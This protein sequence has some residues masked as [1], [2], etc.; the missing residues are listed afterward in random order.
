MYLGFLIRSLIF[1][2]LGELNND[3]DVTV[4]KGLLRQLGYGR[5]SNAR[6]TCF[7]SKE[8]FDD[9][10]QFQKDNGLKVDGVITPNGETARTIDRLFSEKTPDDSWGESDLEKRCAKLL[11]IDE[12]MCASLEKPRRRRGHYKHLPQGQPTAKCWETAR[13][14]YAHCLAGKPLD[15]LPPLNAWNH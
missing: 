4:T 2:P 12:E 15:E 3:I 7:A 1:E 10:R 6:P 13:M 9:I 11:Q 8:F 5:R 14:R